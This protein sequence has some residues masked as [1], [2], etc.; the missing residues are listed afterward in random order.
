MKWYCVEHLNFQVKIENQGS[1]LKP[2]T[3]FAS[4]YNT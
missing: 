4:L 2:I 3:N 1:S